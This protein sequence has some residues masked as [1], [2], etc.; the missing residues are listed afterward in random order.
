[1]SDLR[2]ARAAAIR[3]RWRDLCDDLHRAL[4]L[5]LDELDALDQAQLAT[6]GHVS[7]ELAAAVTSEPEPPSRPQPRSRAARKDGTA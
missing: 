3:R 7:A 4:P 6:G 2:A 1:M 5:L